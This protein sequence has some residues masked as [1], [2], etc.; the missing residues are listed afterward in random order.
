MT[1]WLA[2]VS[3]EELGF[4]YK[5]GSLPPGVTEDDLSLFKDAQQKAQE[6]RK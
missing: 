3:E 5:P 1:N 6:V 4:P 2:H